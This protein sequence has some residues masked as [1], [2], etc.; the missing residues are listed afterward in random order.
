MNTKRQI[1]PKNDEA[2]RPAR[3]APSLH[4]QKEEV[5]PFV[6]CVWKC[7]TLAWESDEGSL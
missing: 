5:Q 6:A 7:R 1:G 3:P 4:T 2:G